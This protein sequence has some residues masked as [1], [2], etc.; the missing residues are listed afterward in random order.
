M[1]FI[2]Y[3]NDFQAEKDGVIFIQFIEPLPFSS[4]KATP[5]AM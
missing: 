5:R 4:Q 2:F 3:Q 1:N